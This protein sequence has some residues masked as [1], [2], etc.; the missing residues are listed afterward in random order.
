MA[1][2]PRERRNQQPSL[3]Q[4]SLSVSRMVHLHFDWLCGSKSSLA[5]AA[6]GRYLHFERSTADRLPASPGCRSPSGQVNETHCRSHQALSGNTPLVSAAPES[7]YPVQD[8][9]TID[10]IRRSLE[11]TPKWDKQ[12][13]GAVIRWKFRRSCAREIP[14]RHMKLM[15]FT[16]VLKGSALQFIKYKL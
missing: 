7:H 6:M 2:G 9:L 4:L 14:P 5:A 1:Y 10:R 12:Q 3:W 8:F 11:L 16:L 13:C 15:L